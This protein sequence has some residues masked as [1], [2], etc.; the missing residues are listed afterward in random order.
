[1]RVVYLNNKITIIYGDLSEIA[2][3]FFEKFV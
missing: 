3:V 2:Q 1:M